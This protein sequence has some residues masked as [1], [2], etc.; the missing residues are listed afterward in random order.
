MCDIR[1]IGRDMG[2]I[3]DLEQGFKIKI[4]PDGSQQEEISKPVW[5]VTV[6]HSENGYQSE[7]R[8]VNYCFS[9]AVAAFFDTLAIYTNDGSITQEQIESAKDLIVNLSPAT[10]G[11]VFYG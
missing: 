8:S 7:F 10:K 1:V 11:V 9:K 2:V 3:V 4:L 6:S 5:H